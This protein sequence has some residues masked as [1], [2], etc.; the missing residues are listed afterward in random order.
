MDYKTSDNL[1][2]W[3]T[4]K[5]LKHCFTTVLFNFDD[6]QAALKLDSEMLGIRLAS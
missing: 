5:F 2:I 6:R 1:E 4:L 3:F